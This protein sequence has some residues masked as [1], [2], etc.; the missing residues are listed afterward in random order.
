M[1]VLLRTCKSLVSLEFLYGM[2]CS[3]RLPLAR[4]ATTLPSMSRLR[5]MFVPSVNLRTTRQEWCHRIGAHAAETHKHG[6][7]Y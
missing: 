7:L 5:L 3:G 1:C 6:A 4:L 2:Y